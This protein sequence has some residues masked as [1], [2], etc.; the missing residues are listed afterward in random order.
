MRRLV[1]FG[2]RQL[3]AVGSPATISVLVIVLAIGTTLALTVLTSQAREREVGAQVAAAFSQ[4]NNLQID[5]LRALFDERR[6]ASM[7]IV[8]AGDDPEGAFLRATQDT[9]AA[10]AALEVA[11]QELLRSNLVSAT[12][13]D[14]TAESLRATAALDQVRAAVLRAGAV[15]AR[16]LYAGLVG[17]VADSLADQAF[18]STDATQVRLRRAATSVLSAARSAADR[19][20]LG[21]RMIATPNDEREERA[22]QLAILERDVAANLSEATRRLDVGEVEAEQTGRP[23]PSALRADLTGSV[24][25]ATVRHLAARLA[26]AEDDV[27]MDRWLDASTEQVEGLLNL[28]QTLQ[29]DAGSRAI[30]AAGAAREARQQAWLVFLGILLLS[31]VAGGASIQTARDHVRALREHRALVDGMLEWFNV[32]PVPVVGFR[33]EARYLAAPQHAGAGGDWYDVFEDPATGTTVAAIGD[34]AGHS[35]RSV[36]RMAEVRN[37]LRGLEGTE[38]GGPAT[39]LR[40]LDTALSHGP[41]TTV[42]LAHLDMHAKRMTFSRAGHVPGVLRRADGQVE[43][44]MG[45]SDL[46]LGVDPTAPRS[47]SSIELHDGDIAVLFT[48]GLVERTR[49]RLDEDIQRLA[50]A[51]RDAPQDGIMDLAELADH[52]IDQL[53]PDERSDD[54]SL[55]LFR[56]DPDPIQ[57][58]ASSNEAAP[59]AEPTSS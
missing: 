55:L 26:T 54:C 51:L 7:F 11:S 34:V 9:D 37:M 47:Q 1:R 50:D 35:A 12:N 46:P 58:I 2:R 40:V 36:A 20:E 24:T 43:L 13:P 38:L 3:A 16:D 45:A 19:R 31:F 5:L 52:L 28:A 4:T 25:A 17:P 49:S 56:P 32:D 33:A 48:D 30:A 59:A 44:L 39:V 41:L 8:D 6:T 53:L 27:T 15:S 21:L 23:L 14:P 10:R 57:V 22:V 18:A 42:F 29:I